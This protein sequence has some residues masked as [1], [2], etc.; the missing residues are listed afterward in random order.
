MCVFP[1]S[2]VRTAAA[3]RAF[4]EL[5]A[6]LRTPRRH[7]HTFAPRARCAAELK[8]ERPG[9]VRRAWVVPWPALANRHARDTRPE[10]IVSH[11]LGTKRCFTLLARS[12]AACWAALSAPIHLSSRAFHHA[13]F[14]RSAPGLSHGGVRAPDVKTRSLTSAPRQRRFSGPNG[15]SFTLDHRAPASAEHW[16][17]LPSGERVRGLCARFEGVG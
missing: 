13:G 15:K 16:I 5:G 10:M 11:R 17:R 9:R 8:N 7:G 3:W 12:P 2:Q 4:R 6:R 1:P 14:A